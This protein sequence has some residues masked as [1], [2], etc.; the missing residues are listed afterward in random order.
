MYKWFLFEGR[1][2][3][4]WKS[5]QSF[6]QSLLFNQHNFWTSLV[7]SY[8]TSSGKKKK[9]RL[10]MWAS[11]AQLTLGRTF[12]LPGF[13]IPH[14][15]KLIIWTGWSILEPNCQ[16]LNPIPP[17][18][19]PCASV[20]YQQSRDDNHTYPHRLVGKITQMNAYE[21]LRTRSRLTGGTMND[22]YYWVLPKQSTVF[23]ET[24]LT[25]IC[26]LVSI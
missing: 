21:R 23:T 8:I 24:S 6:P 5:L 9:K 11:F 1:F 2:S 15:L 22:S 3:P 10:T 13:Q 18:I 16:C 7:Y 19:P 12:S 14:F 20:S 4:C 26:L 25:I 17:F